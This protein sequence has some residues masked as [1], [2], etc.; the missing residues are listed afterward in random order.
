[1]QQALITILL[2]AVL[3]CGDLVPLL[4]DK[5]REQRA[6]WF[7]LPVYAVSLAIMLAFAFGVKMNLEPAL[8]AFL[9]SVLRVG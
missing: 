4:R 5:S 6:V 1:M 2:T 3:V 8:A 9:R 7:A